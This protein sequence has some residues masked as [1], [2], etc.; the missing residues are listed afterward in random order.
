MPAVQPPPPPAQAHFTFAENDAARFWAFHQENPHVYVALRRFALE[1]IATTH[2]RRLSI[3]L[4]FERL[5]WYT[6]IETQGDPFK[7]NNTFRAWYARLLM[8]QEPA[9]AGVFE[10]RR[11]DADEAL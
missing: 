5:R 4:L 6:E 1:A 3:N 7:V 11:S 2:R 9:L 10:T 8:R